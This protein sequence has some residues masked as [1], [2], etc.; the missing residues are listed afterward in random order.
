MAP[1]PQVTARISRINAFPF[2]T[3]LLLPPGQGAAGIDQ[4]KLIES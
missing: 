3:V 4:S 1:S 2:I